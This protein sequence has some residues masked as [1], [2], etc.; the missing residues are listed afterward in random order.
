MY[1]LVNEILAWRRGGFDDKFIG[2]LI[3][4]D[5]GRVEW[6][7]RQYYPDFL[8]EI[9]HCA[10]CGRAFLPLDVVVTW[11]PGAAAQVK[12]CCF[13]CKRSAQNRRAYQRRGVSN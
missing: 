6:V 4:M 3:G 8:V 13:R 7:L 9:H 11:N 2:G 1:D 12:Y 10:T 5:A